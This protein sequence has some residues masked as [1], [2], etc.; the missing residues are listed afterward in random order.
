MQLITFTTEKK[1]E[2]MKPAAKGLVSMAS[3]SG[4]NIN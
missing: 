4:L 3:A 2:N 1:L